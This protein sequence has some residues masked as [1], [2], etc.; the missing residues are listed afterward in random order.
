[1]QQTTAIANPTTPAP[2]DPN[3]PVYTSAELHKMAADQDAQ[4][5]KNVARAKIEQQAGDPLS[6]LGTTADAV[7]VMLVSMAELL[8]WIGK[9]TTLAQ[10]KAAAANNGFAA[11]GAALLADM[12]AGTVSMPYAVKGGIA[13]VMPDIKSRANAVAKVI[14]AK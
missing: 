11:A 14:S 12:Q 10:V 9:A 7:Q 5:R 3:A 13:K 1:M 2:V 4:Y 6:L 8:A